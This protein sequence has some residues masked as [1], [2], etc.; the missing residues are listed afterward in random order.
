[1]SSSLEQHKKIIESMTKALND[2]NIDEFLKYIDDNCQVK[3]DGESLSRSK[4]ELKKQTEQRFLDPNYQHSLVEFLP[5]E[6]SDRIRFIVEHKD[7]KR[8]EQTC[9]FTKEGKIG[10]VSLTS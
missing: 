4:D 2:Q 7:K 10:E 6:D 5:T 8:Y 3:R 1:M 9:I